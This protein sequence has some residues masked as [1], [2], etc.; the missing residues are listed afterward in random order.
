MGNVPFVTS[1]QT[2]TTK[3]LCSVGTVI[4]QIKEQIC[5]KCVVMKKY[6][7]GI[8]SWGKLTWAV[9]IGTIRRGE[10]KEEERKVAEVNGADRMSCVLGSGHT[11]DV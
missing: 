11:G 7:M 3:P 5:V 10:E 4:N 2:Q 9:N 1:P 6:S 8:C